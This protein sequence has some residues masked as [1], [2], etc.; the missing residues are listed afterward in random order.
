MFL[1]PCHFH[2]GMGYTS[3]KNSELL[4]LGR[5]GNPKRLS[6]AVRELMIAARRE[7]SRKPDETFTRIEAYCDGPR[8]E[9]FARESRPGWIGWGFEAKKFDTSPA[10][11]LLAKPEA[12]VVW[13]KR[14]GGAPLRQPPRLHN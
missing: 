14:Q 9:M 10:S 4:L 5:R 12:T 2:V 11:F 13:S 7:H 6:K 1:Q 8:L 3:R